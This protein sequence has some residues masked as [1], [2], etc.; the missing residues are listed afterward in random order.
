MFFFFGDKKTIQRVNKN[1]AFDHDCTIKNKDDRKPPIVVL[2]QKLRSGK[3]VKRF[4]ISLIFFNF[5]PF[6][7]SYIQV[8]IYNNY[9]SKKHWYKKIILHFFQFSSTE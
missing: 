1:K 4:S 9:H 7:Q 2:P 5:H 6:I 3:L 8:N